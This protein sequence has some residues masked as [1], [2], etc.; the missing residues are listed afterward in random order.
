MLEEDQI[1]RRA[2]AL[3]Q[4]TD[5][6]GVKPN[7]LAWVL[8]HL[9]RHRD[10]GA[11]R[12]MLARLVRSPF[13]ARTNQTRRQVAALQA[14]VRDALARDIDWQD[15]ARIVGWARRLARGRH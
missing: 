15:A 3:A 14:A 10:C 9:R 13:A 7:Q 6:A 1:L 5:G 2:W 12:R 4:W 11:T 8:A